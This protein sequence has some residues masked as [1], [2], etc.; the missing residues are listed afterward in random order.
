MKHNRVCIIANKSIFKLYNPKD[1]KKMRCIL[2]RSCNSK[3]KYIYCKCSKNGLQHH[4][5]ESDCL[6]HHMFESDCLKHH[7]FESDCLK[8]HMF[9]SDCLKHHMF[10]HHV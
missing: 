7:M 6:K 2:N 3:N 8:H 1:I 4:M 5:F 10:D 9:E